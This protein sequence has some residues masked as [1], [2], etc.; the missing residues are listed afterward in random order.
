MTYLQ[1]KTQSIFNKKLHMLDVLITVLLLAL[2]FFYMSNAITKPIYVG[3]TDPVEYNEQAILFMQTGQFIDDHWPVGFT[4][5]LG[6][7]Y[8]LFGP[9]YSIFKFLNILLFISIPF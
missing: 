7:I 6:S 4:V 8:K 9:N 5:I 3:N 2:F 1:Q